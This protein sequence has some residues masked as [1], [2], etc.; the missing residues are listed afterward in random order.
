MNKE[1]E[2]IYNRL[3]KNL[4]QRKSIKKDTNAFRLYDRDLP[5][6]PY[7][8]DLYAQSIIIYEKGKN[9]KNDEIELQQRRKAHQENIVQALKSIFPE[10]NQ[11]IF[12]SRKVQKGKQQYI[13]H[14]KRNKYITVFE[15]DRNY[16]INPLD[17]IDC[18]LFLDHRILRKKINEMKLAGTQALHLFCYTGS[19]SVAMAKA[20]AIVTSVDLSNSYIE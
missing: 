9:I 13:P 4:K 3:N 8:I 18:G 12:K 15:S 7:I 19:I 10:Q 6:Y 11:I 14:S 17:Y 2:E 1:Y 16:L 5:Q 20:G